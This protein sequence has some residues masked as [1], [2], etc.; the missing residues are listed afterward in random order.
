MLTMKKLSIAIAGAMFSTFYA[1]L[2]AAHASHPVPSSV[3]TS[4]DSG[5]HEEGM[6]DVLVVPADTGSSYYAS[7]NLYS[8]IASGADTG[9]EFALLDFS[10]SPLL[11]DPVLP[12]LHLHTR[13]SESFYVKNGE[14]TI[15]M[16]DGIN[17]VSPPEIKDWSA[18]KTVTV[19]PGSF[20]YLPKGRIHEFINP[21]TTQVNTLSLLTPPGFENALTFSPPVTDKNAPIPPFTTQGRELY[22]ANASQYGLAC[23]NCA[24][25]DEVLAQLAGQELQD[26]L[27]VPGDAQGRE[28][29]SLEGNQYTSLATDE[30]TGGEFSLFNV[31]LAPQT[32]PGLLQT[33]EQQTESYYITDG[34]VKFLFKNQ[35]LVATPGTF[36]SF[37]EGT[38]YAYQNLGTTPASTLLLRTPAAVPEPS[39]WLGV[40]GCGAFLGAS[41]VFKRKHKKQKSADL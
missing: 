2:E 20:V 26:Y 32:E 14:L 36:V 7:G 24:N 38:P 16:E 19:G 27:V 3:E 23:E 13:E 29:F 25:R 15:F 6:Q 12:P 8:L 4:E 17:L 41:L 35:S 34:E 5:F 22:E 1:G 28:S 9:G 39:S 33:T 11:P 40:L 31:S 10:V 18:I 37:P 21:G 30:E